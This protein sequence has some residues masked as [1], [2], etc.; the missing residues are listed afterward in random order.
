MTKLFQQESDFDRAYCIKFFPRE[1]IPRRR[2]AV[3][4]FQVLPLLGEVSEMCN[5]ARIAGSP[6]RPVILLN[7]RCFPALFEY[8]LIKLEPN[9]D[10][11][12]RISKFNVIYLNQ[13]ESGFSKVVIRS[14]TLRPTLLLQFRR[15]WTIQLMISLQPNSWWNL[16]LEVKF[17]QSQWNFT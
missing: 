2:Y 13:I 12:P 11:W 15:N 7:M 14:P 8:W 4:S 9:V 10:F 17:P 5:Q 3:Y 6:L 16:Q 1:I